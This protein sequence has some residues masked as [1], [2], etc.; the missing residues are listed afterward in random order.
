MIASISLIQRLSGI[1][2][3][4]FRRHWL[5]VH[6]PLVCTFPHLQR[7]VQSHVV[8]GGDVTQQA[9]A[10]PIDGFAE[11][12]FANREDRDVAYNS[13][14]LAACD[15]DSRLFIGQV[16]RVVTDPHEVVALRRADG[17]AKLITL[18]A[19]TAQRTTGN[20][21]IFA[22]QAARFH[23]L[24]GLCGYTQHRVL[25]QHR[26]PRSAVLGL[27]IDVGGLSELWFENAALRQQ[28]LTTVTEQDA[29]V[30]LVEEHEFI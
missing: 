25:D 11:L 6:G 18:F 19:A 3:A 17:V 24:T 15:V 30:Y 4:R 27:S 7:Y 2:T 12:W 13:P 29:A 28:A 16:R 22:R 23:D 10:L 8:E 21:A 20:E 14:A 26:P 1:D 9:R 5:D